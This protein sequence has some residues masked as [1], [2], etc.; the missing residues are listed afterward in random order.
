[1]L[2]YSMV[3]RKLKSR[4]QVILNEASTFEICNNK[5]QLFI[6]RIFIEKEFSLG[7]ASSKG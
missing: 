6:N 1:M 3:K 5:Q 7:M 4:L 2:P